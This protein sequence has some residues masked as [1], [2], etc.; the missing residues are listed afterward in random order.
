MNCS[1]RKKENFSAGFT[2]LEVVVSM[3]ILSMI[4]AI[5]Y[6]A[7]HLG[8]RAWERGE[9]DIE[10]NQRLRIG[11]SF[12]VGDIASAYNY[13]MRVSNQW[14]SLFLGKPDKLL[15]VSSL[16]T[17][18]T[19][20][21]EIGLHHISYF[22]QESSASQSGGLVREEFPITNGEPFEEESG[23]TIMI[24]PWVEEIYFEYLYRKPL[25]QSELLSDVEEEWVE[26]WGGVSGDSVDDLRL[27]LHPGMDPNIS[28]AS[29]RF[30]PTAVRITLTFSQDQDDY[31]SKEPITMEP[32]VVPIGA[33]G[34]YR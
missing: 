3:T 31:S 18:L 16:A 30:L 15:F 34:L 1:K 19:R 7:F 27:A 14:I 5:I 21:P 25:H 2:L 12:L 28:R 17:H 9:R 13:R 11:L 10:F 29:R 6:S 8:H 20:R 22:V 32:I 33:S 26:F 23:E 4:L 24:L